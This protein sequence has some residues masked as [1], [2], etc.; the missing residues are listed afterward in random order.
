MEYTDTIRAERVRGREYS[1]CLLFSPR[2]YVAR[3]GYYYHAPDSYDGAC[4]GYIH[5]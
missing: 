3:F 5:I 4:I 1:I 2:Y